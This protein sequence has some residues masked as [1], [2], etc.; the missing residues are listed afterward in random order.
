MKQKRS[1][2][3]KRKKAIVVLLC[4]LFVC[5]SITVMAEEPVKI[6]DKEY[7]V[8][9]DDAKLMYMSN[10]VPIGGEIGSKVFLTYTVEKVT[11]NTAYQQ[12]V[13]GAKDNK[14]TFPYL[15]NGKMQYAN[16]GKQ[17]LLLDEGY[18][19]IYRFERTE[20]GF[21]YTC[22]KMKDEQIIPI[23]FP[24]YTE[25][26]GSKK[27]DFY[28]IWFDCTEGGVSALLNHVRCYDEKGNDLGV[29]LNGKGGTINSELYEMFD[30]KFVVNS[31]YSFKLEDDYAVAV[32]NKLPTNS[33]V[34]YMEYEV[35]DVLRDDTYQQGLIASWRPRAEY[36]VRDEN[37]FLLYENYEKGKGETPLLRKG[38]KYFICF[39]R[40]EDGFDG[41]V[42]CTVNGKSDIYTFPSHAYTYD[43][44]YP[45][46]S[47]WFDVKVAGDGISATF[48][49]FKCYDS[50]GQSLGVQLNRGDIQVFHKGEVEDYSGSKAVYYCEKKDEFLVL[51]DAKTVIRQSS[52]MKKEGTYKLLG[53]TDLY[54]TIDGAKEGFEYSYVSIT[55]ESGNKYVRLN[56]STVTFVDGDETTI[57][58]VN[59]STGYMVAEPT[60]PTKKGDTFEGWCLK[61]GT[62]FDFSKIVTESVTLYA[63]WQNGPEY[64]ET[65]NVSAMIVSITVSALVVVGCGI[66]CY[67]I[68]RRRKNENKA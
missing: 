34:I 42:Q 1:L 62:E 23:R 53:D 68:V 9:F 22:F 2:L 44:K 63:K 57:V 61:D 16:Y 32:S 39:V 40:N 51:Q 66:G 45:Y 56:D 58:K 49:N 3:T 12:G 50:E 6:S 60:E 59:A 15:E 26:A 19:Y 10:D 36:P 4:L 55:D 5:N 14:A 30:E 65:N 38:G 7:V 29:H 33:D 20:S 13:V 52:G 31:S 8:E 27:Y 67:L 25:A 47:I 21:D 35:E 41:I 54:I 24:S 17:S 18:T 46:F 43:S 64:T 48:K 28:G 37:G 11:E